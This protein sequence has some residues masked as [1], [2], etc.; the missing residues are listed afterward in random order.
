MG[1]L[2]ILAQQIQ[3]NTTLISVD[4]SNHNKGQ[5]MSLIGPTYTSVLLFKLHTEAEYNTWYQ[6]KGTSHTL[7]VFDLGE[8]LYEPNRHY[9]SEPRNVPLLPINNFAVC[10]LSHDSWTIYKEKILCMQQPHWYCILSTN[11]VWLIKRFIYFENHQEKLPYQSCQYA[12]KWKAA[13]FK[14]RLTSDRCPFISCWG[15]EV[16][17]H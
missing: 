3:P 15:W 6:A 1:V 7:H 14:R 12:L 16:P 11:V 9:G 17:S 10:H 8:Q 5:A 2:I 13:L 4:Y